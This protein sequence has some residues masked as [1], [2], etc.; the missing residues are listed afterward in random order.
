MLFMEDRPNKAGLEK[1]D[2]IVALD[3]EQVNDPDSLQTLLS[4]KKV[5]DKITLGIWRNS[6]RLSVSLNLAEK[7]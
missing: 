1:Y 6:K 4:N 5:G 3:G 2:V 7:P